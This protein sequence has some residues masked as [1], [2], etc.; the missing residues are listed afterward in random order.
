MTLDDCWMIGAGNMGRALLQGWQAAGLPVGDMMVVDPQ[1]PDLPGGGRALAALPENAAPPRAVV[2]AIKPQFFAAVAADLAPRLAR[3]TRVISMLAG[4]RVERIRSALGADHVCRIMPNLPVAIG[5]G[6][7]GAW[8]DT[9]DAELRSL[10]DTLGGAVGLLEWLEE[11][12]QL[13]AFTALGG[14]SP[15]FALRFAAALADAAAEQGLK[16][17]QSR[18]IALAVL[19]GAA[20]LAATSD[21]SIEAL[22]DSVAS[23]GGAT[24]A[25]LDQ[26]DANDALRSLVGQAVGAATLRSRELS[27]E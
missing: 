20:G 10:V 26:L 14:C 19:S 17:D 16:L 9:P 15:A 13:D 11:E 5:L 1:Q 21:R 22:V 24:R 4:T 3:R 18:R 6:A 25:G 8:T 7:T 27:H 23:K 12:D 2:L